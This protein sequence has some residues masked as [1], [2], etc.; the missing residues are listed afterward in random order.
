MATKE[1][2]AG[3]VVVIDKTTQLSELVIGA[4]AELR[5]PEGYY[6]AMTVDSIGTPIEEGTYKGDIVLTVAKVFT[7]ETYRFGVYSNSDYQAGVIINDGHYVK[8][9]SVPSILRGGSFDEHSA[10]GMEI[11]SNQW[12]FNGFFVTGDSDYTISDVKINLSGD[13][14]DDFVGLGAGIAVSG[15]ARVTVNNA[16]IHST[17][18]GRGTAFVGSDSEV[19]FNDCFFTLDTGHP[20]EE[21]LAEKAQDRMLEPPWQMGIR[22]YGRT[23]N[24]AGMATVNYN[25]CHFI[26]NSW[27][28]LSIDGGCVTRMNAKD[29]LVELRGDSGYGCFSIADDVAFDYEKFGDYGAYN[30]MDHCVINV[31]TY[32][33][34]MSNGKSGGAFINGST[35]N[36]KRFGCLIFRNSGGKLE[37][38]SGTTMNTGKATFLMKG[39]N[40]YIECDD[41]HLNPANGVILQVMDSDETGMGGGAFNIPIGEKDKKIRGRDLTVAVPTEDIF[42]SFSNMTVKGD[43]FNS[44]TNLLANCRPDPFAD[45]NKAHDGPPPMDFG[46]IRGMGT[47]LQG[48]KNVD[49]SFK[50][51][52]VEGLITAASASYRKGLTRIE[53]E[54][55]EDL[56]DITCTAA[57]PV[58]NGVIVSLDRYSEWTVTGKCYLTKLAIARGA[59]IKGVKGKTVKMTVDGEKTPIEA[60]TYTG[61][62]I[63]T[64]S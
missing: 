29:C 37:V 17:G 56:G 1:I 5:A 59:V 44:T 22:G 48:P 39:T 33:I 58:N 53:K 25:R 16:E 27:G 47:D 43:M 54:N 14:T 35:I 46:Q 24:V 28:V 45:P 50:N 36:S 62:I 7:K 15:S 10:Q 60:G 38:K 19:T 31:P 4:G 12:D 63:L 42:A 11:T 6:L 40:S 55:C 26:S 32:P 61:K 2:K 8:E 34:I 57:A 9:S 49:I 18:L 51:A 52:K 30:V 3:E 20:S 21:E 64:V 41:A 13:G 23:T